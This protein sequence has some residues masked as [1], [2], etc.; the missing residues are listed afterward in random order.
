MDD[1]EKRGPAPQ[2]Q[3][4]QALAD[5]SVPGAAGPEDTRP[6]RLA[7]DRSTHQGLPPDQAGDL[8]PP[9][10]PSTPGDTQPVT[11]VLDHMDAGMRREI[12]NSNLDAV[13]QSDPN[14][15]PDRHSA[16]ALRDMVHGGTMPVAVDN[17][18][19]ELIQIW[20]S[21]TSGGENEGKV[22]VTLMRALNLVV[23]V[24]ND[25][26]ADAAT[27][28]VRR[29]VG[30]HPCR[31][32]MVVNRSGVT[33]G[34]APDGVDPNADNDLEATLSAHCEI[35]D[36]SGKHVCCEQVTISANSSE[37]LTRVSNLA[38]NLLITDLPVFLWWAAG[39]PFNNT[40]LSHLEDSIDRL[41]VDSQTFPDPVAGLLAM[42]RAADPAARHNDTVRYAPTDF[43]WQ[44]MGGWREATAA[45]FD[46]PDL[47][48]SL[49][50]M[51]SIEVQY[52]APAEGGTPN[53]VQG[54]LYA[55][56]LATRLNWEFHSSAPPTGRSAPGNFVLTLR[57]G[58]RSIPIVLSVGQNAGASG[59]I[60]SVR[61]TTNEANP[62][63][64][65]ISLAGDSLYVDCVVEREGTE[66]TARKV[67]YS[68]PD[69]VGLLDTEMEQFGHDPIY[70]EA[71][72]MAG[73]MS[74]SSLSYSRRAEI[75]AQLGTE[76]RHSSFDPRF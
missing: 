67:R 38:L 32:I 44:R 5:Q 60:T 27:D 26:Q 2:D 53:P 70:E 51:G 28:T 34:A 52:A 48:A 54:F 19:R 29:I 41:I 75:S 12:H 10:M 37:A 21:T 15:R 59:S 24:E 14:V 56:W 22:S 7:P 50:R 40:V 42:A 3:E 33:R 57:Q 58:M 8:G 43:N 23:Y 6:A 30:R 17:L 65:S 69:E 16:S 74:W 36:T 47:N 20:K 55:A 11:H 72:I 66:T 31:T 71:L 4:V 73:T 9:A 62:M 1:D 46:A 63:T 25:D 49:W 76:S 61:L 68:M 45:V 18:D 64:F 13:A 35:A 39:P